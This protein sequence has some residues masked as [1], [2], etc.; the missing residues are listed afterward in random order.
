MS[1]SAVQEQ[2][3][4][5][6]GVFQLP[7][8]QLK[9]VEEAP[10]EIRAQF[11]VRKSDDSFGMA[12]LEASLLHHGLIYPLI[13]DR[14]H[15]ADYAIAGNR[16]L[17]CLRKIH[18]NNPAID[19]NV[20][21]VRDFAGDEREIAMA[22]NIALP[23]HP[24]DR[25]EVL[26][27]QVNA[28]MSPEDVA[29]RYAMTLQQVGRVLALA[30]LAPE[31]R[32]AWRDEKIDAQVAQA[33]TLAPDKAEQVKLFKALDKTN[34]I[35]AW[36]IREKF[37]KNRD[38]GKTLE[39]VG[40][41]AYENA[42]GKV[43]R[44]LFGT[45]HTVSDEKLLNKLYLTQMDAACQTLLDEG[46][47]FAF[48]TDSLGST[49]YSYGQIDVAKVTMTKAEKETQAALTARVEASDDDSE[50][51]EQLEAL[52][53]AVKLR[54][55]TADHKKR[56][57]CFLSVA[58][59]GSLDIEYGRVKPS[60]KS[61][62]KAPAATKAKEKG[63]KAKAPEVSSVVAFR[64]DQQLLKATAA[65]IIAAS[66]GKG[67]GPMLASIVATQIT[68]T[69]PMGI[70]MPVSAMLGD[71]RLVID[72]KIMQRQIKEAFDAKD[73]F[74]SIPRDMI[75]AAVSE[76]ISVDQATKVRSMSKEQAAK[77]AVSNVPKT[78]WLPKQLRMRGYD[79]PKAKK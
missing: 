17:K 76:S 61:K 31:I 54:A 28:G 48:T 19:V 59:D 65:A 39:F 67:L 14:S 77:Y 60:E 34:N 46:W 74:N 29:A 7:L 25:Y 64:L 78:G 66:P 52:E 70:P 3:L 72:V 27:A 30:E 18:A 13:L 10:A 53:A 57:G 38:V 23:P 6:V 8:S 4:Q 20:V 32:D 63:G 12:E 58:H 49:R 43:K 71:I 35:S 36:Q 22:V 56:S 62:A 37:V 9:L 42:G 1:K 5:N 45:S 73:Y 75:A 79:A 2:T 40:I 47:S 24:V 16:R 50:A 68:W 26:A 51:A 21:D 41:D 44:D 33:F 55:Y 69:R 11:Q 15:G